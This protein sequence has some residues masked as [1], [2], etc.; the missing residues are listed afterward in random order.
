M[1]VSKLVDEVRSTLDDELIRAN[2]I[3]KTEHEKNLHSAK[4]RLR[5]ETEDAVDAEGIIPDSSYRNDT[6]NISNL[7]SGGAL[8][9]AMNCVRWMGV[10]ELE[11][12]TSVL[13]GR[14]RDLEDQFLAGGIDV[15]GEFLS[16]CRER[17]RGE[18][19]LL[20]SRLSVLDGHIAAAEGAIGN[21]NVPVDDMDSG[22]G[23]DFSIKRKQISEHL[24]ELRGTYLQC[25]V[26]GGEGL[27]GFCEKFST[28][29]RRLQCIAKL[30]YNS[31]S[32]A[33]SRYRTSS[34]IVSS[35]EFDAGE[36]RFATAGVSKRIHVYDFD[37][38]ISNDNNGNHL[39]LDLGT[40][41][42]LSCLSWCKFAKNQLASSDYEGIVNVWDVEKAQSFIEYEEH[43]KRVWTVD[44]SRTS[45]PMMVSGSDDGKV[46]VWSVTQPN[47]VCT[48][49][50]R[51]NVCCVKYNPATHHQ[52]AVGCA[53]HNVHIFD[54]R[55]I[56]YP[57]EVLSGHK[58]AVSYVRY[59]SSTEVVSASTDGT[60]RVWEVGGDKSVKT[61]SGHTNEKNFV[62]LSVTS[63][64]VCCG[65]ETNDVYV[66][67][68][69]VSRPLA[70]YNFNNDD[71]RQE[72]ENQ[73]GERNNN[74]NSAHVPL[75]GGASENAGNLNFANSDNSRQ[76]RQQQQQQQQQRQQPNAGR[77][78]SETN[79]FI[80]SLC[81][82]GESS[83]LLASNSQGSIRAIT[84]E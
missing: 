7:Q 24:D 64:F 38:L 21:G 32:N 76:Q 5:T 77:N 46:K 45:C 65:S 49:D 37:S 11:A 36:E 23:I 17:K 54:L 9:R 35:I 3:N 42:K 81:W 14:R 62:G 18:L 69:H 75:L 70:K 60:L 26:S 10:D 71:F 63:Q 1:I 29:L 6:G 4:K 83:V 52:V 2:N 20:Q 67:Y 59:A 48:I 44:F 56:G 28:F 39:L 16:R 15:L 78:A 66:Y 33:H 53:D 58:K 82:K 27:S 72:N 61:L 73:D 68:K 51:A 79:Q 55:K 57:L 31:E 22:N 41:S 8:A 80:S 12:M 34:N 47:S 30:D 40:R 19:R 84:L 25:G 43:E 50:M 13:D 74:I